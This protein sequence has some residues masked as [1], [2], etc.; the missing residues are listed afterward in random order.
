MSTNIALQH[1][2]VLGIDRSP[3]TGIYVLSEQVIVYFAGNN[4]VQHNL[5]SK[6]QRFIAYTDSERGDAKCVAVTTNATLMAFALEMEASIIHI[7]DLQSWSRRPSINLPSGFS[8]T[9]FTALAFSGNSK[10]LIAQG[11]SAD[12][13]LFYFD[14]KSGN[15]LGFQKV[16]TTTPGSSGNTVNCISF[17]PNE[18]NSI[19]CSGRGVF[20]QLTRSDKGFTVKQSSMTNKD[21]LD[22]KSHIWTMDG[23]TIILAL[24]D[25][26][27]SQ[28]DSS[29][30]RVDINLNNTSGTAVTQLTAT[31]KGFICV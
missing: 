11:T 14:V 31:P 4:I 9:P 2:R 1:F 23:R 19:C 17:N 8:P 26:R 29:S 12:S 25:G 22:F 30:L 28:V 16:T 6:E 18:P 27:L 5:E 13:T 20:R 21:T 24:A 10:F 3:N 7:V 15:L